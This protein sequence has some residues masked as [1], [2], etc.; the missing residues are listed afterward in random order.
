MNPTEIKRLGSI[1]D[2]GHFREYLSGAAS[3]DSM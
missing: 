3:K 2:D 1:R